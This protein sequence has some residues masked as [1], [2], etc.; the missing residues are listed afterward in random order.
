MSMVE[1]W[2]YQIKVVGV[3]KYLTVIGN[4]SCPKCKP[5]QMSF[6]WDIKEYWFICQYC[7]FETKHVSIV[8]IELIQF[9][10]TFAIDD[11]Y[12]QSI[13]RGHVNDPPTII[14]ICNDLVKAIY[15][16]KLHQ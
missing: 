10:L 4:K 14:P 7:G 8:N 9:V 2:L 5:F 12:I 6:N 15:N 3:I 13:Q 11:P 1:Q 16:I